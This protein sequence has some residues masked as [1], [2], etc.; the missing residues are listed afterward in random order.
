MDDG[1]DVVDGAPVEL[2]S[3]LD[4]VLVPVTPEQARQRVLRDV[5]RLRQLGTQLLGS[6]RQRQAFSAQLQR[7]VEQLTGVATASA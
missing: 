7:P 3:N 1:V 5:V 2:R 6:R 4:A